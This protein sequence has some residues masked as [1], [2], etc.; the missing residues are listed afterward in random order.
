MHTFIV[1]DAIFKIPT[2]ISE[3]KLH[4]MGSYEQ[5]LDGEMNFSHWTYKINNILNPIFGQPLVETT[6]KT[7][8]FNGKYCRVTVSSLE[9]SSKNR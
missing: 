5:C 3:G 6:N 7:S 1:F 8:K 2:G 4:W 9:V